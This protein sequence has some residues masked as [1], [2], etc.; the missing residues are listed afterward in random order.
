[1]FLIL[2]NIITI[3]YYDNYLFRLWACHGYP[4]LSNIMVYTSILIS[5]AIAIE[6]V[7]NKC[8]ILINF[9]HINEHSSSQYLFFSLFQYR[10]LIKSL[11]DV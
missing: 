8:L 1:M 5:I 10:I 6:G 3:I 7:L 9:V 4:Y 11:H 2:T